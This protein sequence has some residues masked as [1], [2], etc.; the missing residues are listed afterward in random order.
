MNYNDFELEKLLY[1][2][3]RF[4]I[5]FETRQ[6][7]ESILS[8]LNFN[9]PKYDCDVICD[10]WQGLKDHVKKSHGKYLWYG[11]CDIFFILI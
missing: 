3:E 6:L 10:D 2:D 4:G 11:I 9:C 5:F 7:M 1:R 8:V